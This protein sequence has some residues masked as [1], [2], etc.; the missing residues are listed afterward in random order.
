MKQGTVSK[1]TLVK[2]VKVTKVLHFIIINLSIFEIKND[3][4]YLQIWLIKAKLKLD[5]NHTRRNN[6]QEIDWNF[7]VTD[8]VR[9]AIWHHLFLEF[10]LVSTW[11]FA[12]WRHQRAVTHVENVRQLNIR[13]GKKLGFQLSHRQQLEHVKATS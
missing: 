2:S 5:Y 4:T 12:H 11:F 7:T 10:W 9:P 8:I 3:S 1:N 6:I 13:R